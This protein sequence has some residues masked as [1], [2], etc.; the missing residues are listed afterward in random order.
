MEEYRLKLEH[1]YDMDERDITIGVTSKSK[2]TFDKKLYHKKKF[3]QTLHDNNREWV[4][5]LAT[6]CADGTILPPG[7][8][9]TATGHAVQV[10]W[11]KDIDPKLH[12]V[13]FMTSINRWRNDDSK[14]T[15]L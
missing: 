10:S 4:T 12:S 8:T 3:K 6:I 11:V 14:W 15:W 9:F 5:L 7:I 2:R 1:K 13:H